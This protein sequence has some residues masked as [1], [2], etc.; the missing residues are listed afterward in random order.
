MLH[1]AHPE[2]PAPA[3][4]RT[5]YSYAQRVDQYRRRLSE[6]ASAAVVRANAS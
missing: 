4:D 2:R 1:V 5:S 3:L 6:L